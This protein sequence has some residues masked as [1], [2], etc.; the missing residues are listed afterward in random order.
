[1]STR[2][3]CVLSRCSGAIAACGGGVQRPAEMLARVAQPDFEAVKAEHFA[4]ERADERQ[5]FSERRRRLAFAGRKIARELAGK[6]RP[7]LRAAADHHRV[8]MRSGKRRIGVVEAFDV[9]VDDH[10]DRHGRLDGAHRRPIGA[11]FVELAA[12]AAMHSHEPYAGP[13][14]PPRQL[15]RVARKIVPAEPHFQRH[16]NA[17]RGHH[18]LDQRERMR[19]IPHQRR[20]RRAARDVLG[21]AAHVDVDDA[22]AGTFRNARAFRHPA[23]LA[24]GKL[25]DVQPRPVILDAPP[26]HALAVGERRARRHFRDHQ[27]RAQPGGHA[28]ERRIGDAR[29]RR[30]QHR[31][32]QRDGADGNGLLHGGL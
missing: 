13:L 18:G 26:R 15:G 22:G 3:R 2:V 25:H 9:A 31:I 7:S 14:R 23:R 8:G 11:A 32:G 16:W 29:H 17:H 20:S 21:R 5:L 27:P 24:A 6:P 30:Q 19:K 12:R 4:V 10:R 1:M 28:P